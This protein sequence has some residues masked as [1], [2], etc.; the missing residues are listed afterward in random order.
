MP[1]PFRMVLQMWTP[2][3]EGL[4]GYIDAEAY[5]RF[6]EQQLDDYEKERERLLA[7][8]DDLRSSEEEVLTMRWCVAAPAGALLL[9]W[10]WMCPVRGRKRGASGSSEAQMSPPPPPAPVGGG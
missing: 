3:V 6:C 10:R 7:S 9:P 4:E 8:L 1:P 2:E 5:T